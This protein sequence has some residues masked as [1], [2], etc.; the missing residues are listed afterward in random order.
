LN[1]LRVVIENGG[2]S[3]SRERVRNVLRIIDLLPGTYLVGI[4]SILVSS[5]TSVS[6][7]MQQERSL[8]ASKDAAT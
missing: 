7:I 3:H 5:R 2:R 4:V 1:G 8:S 6:A